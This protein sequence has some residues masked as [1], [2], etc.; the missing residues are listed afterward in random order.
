MTAVTLAQAARQLEINIR[1]NIPTMLVGP[2]GVGKT[3]LIRQVCA[4]LGLP[5]IEKRASQMAATDLTL[6]MPDHTTGRIK[7]FVPDWLPD[8]TRD[9]LKGAILFDELSDASISVQ[10]ALN[11]LFLEGELPGYKKP[12]GWIILATGNRASDKA[13]AQKFSRATANRLAI[14]EIK[15]DVK[16]WLDWAANHGIAAELIAY[17]A[18]ADRMGVGE[19]ALHRYPVAGSDAIAFCTNRSL[20]RCSDY[21]K[22]GLNDSDLQACIAANCGDDTAL[23]ILNYL[24]TYRLLPSFQ[25]I[26]A[27]PANAPM[28][29][30]PSVNFALM[31]ALV[32][33]LTM[34]NLP[35]VVTY[36][37][38]MDRLYQAAFWDTAKSKDSAFEETAEHVAFL[39]AQSRAS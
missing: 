3:D 5:I 13:A 19:L 39:L 21:F 4:K 18:N 33:Q 14:I 29:R 9:G 36:V 32:S 37:K 23:D 35:V 16:T 8:E 11:Q 2:V 26:L 27:D 24:A 15:N 31:V 1:F 12:A 28:H 7:N 22:A 20:S 17:V 34:K 25:S 38:R 10:A 30:E 6:P